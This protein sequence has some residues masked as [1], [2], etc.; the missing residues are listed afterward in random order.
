[1][2]GKRSRHTTI[3][4][5]LIVLAVAAIFRF[6]SSAIPRMNID[7]G[8]NYYLCRNPVG[9][10]LRYLQK[11][12]NP[13]LPFLFMKGW[14]AVAGH[15][16]W[17]MRI[18]FAAIA[19]L[20]VYLVFLLAGR[21]FDRRVALGAAAL[22]SVSYLQWE[23]DTWMRG[24]GML[25]MFTL[26][27]TW[28]FLGVVERE[29]PRRVAWGMGYAL[30]GALLL[31]SHYTGVLVLVAHFALALLPDP[32]KQWLE[33]GRRFR[34]LAAAWL[35]MALLMLPWLPI[36][37]LQITRR[38]G[39][40]LQASPDPI[41]A[42]V[43]LLRLLPLET[44]L[45][46]LP[47]LLGSGQAV[48]LGCLALFSGL[49]IWMLAVGWRA[50]RR[51]ATSLR[52]VVALLCPSLLFVVAAFR[53]PELTRVRYYVDTI[54]FFAMLLASGLLASRGAVRVVFAAVAALALA[55]NL[56]VFASYLR[57]P[58][59]RTADWLTPA[60]FALEAQ[61]RAQVIVVSDPFAVHAFNYYYA[62]DLVDYDV[63]D[64]EQPSYRYA[65]AY[66][67]SGRLPE[68]RLYPQEMAAPNAL[69]DVDRA[70]G[71]ILVLWLE[72]PA[73][74]A[75]FAERFS[76][77]TGRAVENHAIDGRSETYLLESGV[78]PGP[79]NRTGR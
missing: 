78:R 79:A 72:A 75:W 56:I 10:I 55:V 14:M 36:L 38:A 47:L 74:R 60:R 70:R 35:A 37:H 8:W 68:R 64:I 41:A 43:M 44:G 23:Y 45:D 25:T 13:P 69:A 63:A 49:G 15:D 62:R 7:E 76:V 50:S 28:T 57:S 27:S 16:E 19:T 73:V 26:L 20:N 18:P 61:S 40:D 59:F 3:V 42:L 53:L 52:V 9:E 58:Y 2:D 54:P 77:L 17:P 1:M 67:A 24:Y 30:A 22:S 34:L 71:A 4:T 39:R 12:R 31:Y 65:P 11:D 66:F 21:L 29:S 33:V 32:D 46:N 48:S 5:L 6:G 51:S